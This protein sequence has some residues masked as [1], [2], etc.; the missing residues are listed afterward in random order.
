[1]NITYAL[2]RHAQR[3]AV[4]FL[5]GWEDGLAP[6]WDR[7]YWRGCCGVIR[8]GLQRVWSKEKLYGEEG[9]YSITFPGDPYTDPED[10][11]EGHRIDL[12][13]GPY[14][15]ARYIAITGQAEVEQGGG[16]IAY[17]KL[18]DESVY[19]CKG[20]RAAYINQE[21][22]YCSTTVFSG[23]RV[24]RSKFTRGSVTVDDGGVLEYATIGT[25]AKLYV[26]AGG[27]ALEIS[28]RPEDCIV[29]DGG[30]LTFGEGANRPELD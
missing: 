6:Q 17:M 8:G 18:R 23:G 4:D 28:A 27:R 11:T 25:G 1:M 3:M 15:R 2:A 14:G 16:S 24:M 29:E 13:V 9:T 10:G 30:V 12:Y 19:M 22:E 26:S 5:P 20:G 7:T 21:G